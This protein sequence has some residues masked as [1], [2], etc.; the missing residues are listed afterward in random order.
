[1]A[2]KIRGAV[3]ILLVEDTPDDVMITQRALKEAKL[4]NRLHVARDGQEALD[5]LWHC[6]AADKDAGPL[7]GLILLDINMPKMSG[8]D[9]LRRIKSDNNLKKIPTVILTVSQKEEDIEKGYY[10]GCNSFIQKPVEFEKFVEVVKQ[11]GLYW[12]FI[13]VNIPEGL[14]RGAPKS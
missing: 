2:Q 8:L 14:E 7:P 13:N 5:Y 6:E 12:G 9:V 3:K 10:Y 1:M 11:I 4:L